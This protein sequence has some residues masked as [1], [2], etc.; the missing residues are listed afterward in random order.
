MSSADQSLYSHHRCRARRS[1]CVYLI[2]CALMMTSDLSL[3]DVGRAEP[4]QQAWLIDEADQPGEV[5]DLI[6]HEEWTRVLLA[7]VSSTGEVDY[8]ALY[9]REIRVDFQ[10]TL[11]SWRRISLLDQAGGPP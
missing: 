8:P 2:F 9:R 3:F 10:D 5:R 6:S 4:T 1:M 7:V 11:K